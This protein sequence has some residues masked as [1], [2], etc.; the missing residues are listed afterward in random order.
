MFLLIGGSY[1]LYQFYIAL[2]Q[3]VMYETKTHVYDNESMRT[4][5]CRNW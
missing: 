2:I 4:T 1:S 5:L 3:L